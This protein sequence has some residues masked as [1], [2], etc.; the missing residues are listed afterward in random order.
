MATKGGAHGYDFLTSWN[1]A[2]DPQIITHPCGKEISPPSTLQATCNELLVAN[3]LLVDLPDDQFISIDGST[4]SR[5][6]AYEALYG[7]RNLTIYGNEPITNAVVTI[8]GHSQSGDFSDPISNGG[9]TTSNSYVDYEITWTSTSSQIMVQVAGHTAV[10]G[11][12]TV[13]WSGTWIGF[14]FGR[15]MALQV[16]YSL[17]PPC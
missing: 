2:N 9:D 8:R 5:I 15:V 16:L 3:S 14:Y 13:F 17:Q 6:A 4:Q 7:N 11:D 12:G 1:K 10:S